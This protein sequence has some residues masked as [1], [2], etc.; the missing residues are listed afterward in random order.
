MKPVVKV[1]SQTCEI[2]DVT[3]LFFDMTDCGLRHFGIICD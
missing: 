3:C 2:Q 1:D